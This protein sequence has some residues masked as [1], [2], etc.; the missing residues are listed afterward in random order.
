MLTSTELTILHSTFSNNLGPDILVSTKL[1]M[2]IFKF[3]ALNASHTKIL[4]SLYHRVHE[5][6][7]KITSTNR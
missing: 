4:V 1:M 6:N 2:K 7:N 5:S 3:L